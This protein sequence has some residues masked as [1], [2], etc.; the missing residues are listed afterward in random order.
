VGSP[1]LPI[2][3]PN[4]GSGTARQGQAEHATYNKGD[5]ADIMNDL[6]VMAFQCDLTRVIT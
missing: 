5:H 3:K 4:D 1:A 6:V 2:G